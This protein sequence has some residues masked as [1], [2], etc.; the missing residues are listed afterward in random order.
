MQLKTAYSDAFVAVC[1]KTRVAP[2]GV[3]LLK[4]RQAA[5]TPRALGGADTHT[6]SRRRKMSNEATITSV[7]RI[8]Q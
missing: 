4:R 1:G 7:I 6:T 5:L 3:A 2:I 8:D